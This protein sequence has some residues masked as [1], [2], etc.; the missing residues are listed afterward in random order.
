MRNKNIKHILALVVIALIFSSCYKQE[1]EGVIST[2]EKVVA[3]ITPNFFN[4]EVVEGDTLSYTITLSK[5][6]EFATT[7][8]I[9]VDEESS[10]FDWHNLEI[11]DATIAAYSL[12]AELLVIFLA[13]PTPENT[14]NLAFEVGCYN[15][16]EMYT[17][18]ETTEFLSQD[19]MVKNLV[20][21]T[22]VV[23]AFG[24]DVPENDIDLFGI[25]DDSGTNVDWALA[26]TA[27]NPEVMTTINVDHPE[28]G[29]DPDGDYFITIDPYHME[30]T[31]FNWTASVGYPNGQ[32]EIFNGTFD[33][34]NID[35]YTVDYFAYWD[36]NTYRVLVINRNG[37]SYSTTQVMQ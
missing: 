25:Y 19:I 37:D 28:F 9:D 13:S 16:S 17:L 30:G 12:E 20:D 31:S 5:M 14:K 33:I 3:T 4:T 7:F 32:V 23:V 11:I 15:T 21:T 1:V 8:T 35:G 26:G 6:M 2:D 24:W 10:T 27:N 18:H 29:P 34:N 36:V 22:A